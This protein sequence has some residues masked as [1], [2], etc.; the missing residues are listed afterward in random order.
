FGGYSH[1]YQKDGAAAAFALDRYDASKAPQLY[2]PELVNGVRQARNPVNGAIAPAVL[3]GAVVP[4]TGDP[5]NGLVLGSDTS[6]PKG[7]REAP[8]ILVE[9]RLGP[10]GDVTGIGKTPPPP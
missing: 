8:S 3:I 5:N 9:P 10:P 7:F 4:G 6:Y 1:W 2:Q